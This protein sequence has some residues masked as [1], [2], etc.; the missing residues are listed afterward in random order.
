M[1]VV[2]P[3]STVAGAL[4]YRERSSGSYGFMGDLPAA[5]WP[6]QQR[7]PRDR[8]RP[9][10]GVT[11]RWRLL[12]IKKPGGGDERPARRIRSRY[13]APSGSSILYRGTPPRAVQRR[14]HLLAMRPSGE[15]TATSRWWVRRMWECGGELSRHEKRAARIAS[16]LSAL[17][18]AP[19]SVTS[20]IWL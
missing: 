15:M 4:Q 17:N 14:G 9:R 8:S 16:V 10:F 19:L 6:R 18:L 13:E 7:Y 5:R 2:S 1:K 3:P 20:G 11:K 12:R